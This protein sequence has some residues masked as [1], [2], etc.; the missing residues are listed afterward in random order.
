MAYKI[1]KFTHYLSIIYLICSTTFI[2]LLF[3]SLRL[4]RRNYLYIS[5][6]QQYLSETLLIGTVFGILFFIISFTLLLVS[7]KFSLIKYT[8]V[9]KTKKY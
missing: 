3:I 9:F 8:S 4:M 5:F 2:A 7:F 6:L 1:I